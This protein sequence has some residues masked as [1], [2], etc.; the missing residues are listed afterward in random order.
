MESSSHLIQTE[1]KDKT[2]HFKLKLFSLITQTQVVCSSAMHLIR[3]VIASTLLL[4]TAFALPQARRYDS[5]QPLPIVPPE[6]DEPKRWTPDDPVIT[7][8]TSPE[9][10]PSRLPRILPQTFGMPL[11]NFA[12]TSRHR[13]SLPY[14]DGPVV[15]LRPPG[16][17][18]QQRL[19]YIPSHNYPPSSLASGQLR[20]PGLVPPRRGGQERPRPSG[21]AIYA[22]YPSSSSFAATQSRFGPPPDPGVQRSQQRSR[23]QSHQRQPSLAP[24]YATSQNYRSSSMAWTQSE[25]VYPSQS[26]QDA[27]PPPGYSNTRRVRSSNRNTRH[28]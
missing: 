28:P 26:N 27:P 20:P 14:N 19:P 3:L 10:A 13:P 7:P 25:P 24:A 5:R 2:H 18:S 9:M 11:H 6:P 23:S 15:P 1:R 22:Q 8:E 17:S 16:Q 21:P 4:S 12:G